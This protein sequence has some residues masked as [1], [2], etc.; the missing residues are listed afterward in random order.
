MFYVKHHI[1]AMP[2]DLNTSGVTADLCV[3]VTG[4]NV[5]TRCADCGRE[6]PIDLLDWAET[7]PE[8]DYDLSIYC[9]ECT[10]KRWGLGLGTRRKP[11]RCKPC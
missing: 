9:E 3:E 4:Y 5:F 2:G 11:G 10:D 8:F 7:V 1:A 6:L